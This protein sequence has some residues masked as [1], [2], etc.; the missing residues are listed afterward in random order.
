MWQPESA[1]QVRSVILEGSVKSWVV[2]GLDLLSSTPGITVVGGFPF[3]ASPESPCASEAHS[4]FSAGN[5][6]NLNRPLTPVAW[7]LDPLQ[8]DNFMLVRQPGAS[9]IA[10]VTG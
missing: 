8:D 2:S 9:N 7:W 6:S 5:G 3:T 4:P 10:L 1:Q